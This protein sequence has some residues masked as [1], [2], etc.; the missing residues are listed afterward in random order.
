[1]NIFAL[2]IVAVA[3]EILYYAI[4]GTSPDDKKDK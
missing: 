2:V 4:T 3:L 1:V